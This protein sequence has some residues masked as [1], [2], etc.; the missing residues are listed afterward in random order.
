LTSSFF[1]A[2]VLHSTSLPFTEKFRNKISL[3]KLFGKNGEKKELAFSIIDHPFINEY[4][5][6]W[7]EMGNFL[8]RQY[9]GTDSTISKVS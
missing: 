2:R 3:A 6:N 8:S 1:E 7:R 5:F 4:K 9:T